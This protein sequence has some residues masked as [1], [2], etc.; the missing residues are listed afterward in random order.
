[1]PQDATQISPSS[2]SAG[3]DAED[4]V[5]RR[6]FLKDLGWTPDSLKLSIVPCFVVFIVLG[7]LLGVC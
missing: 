3:S 1:M 7:V 6:E 2:S 4:Q 5:A